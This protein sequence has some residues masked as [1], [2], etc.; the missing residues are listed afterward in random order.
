MERWDNTNGRLAPR[1]GI[2]QQDRSGNVGPAPSASDWRSALPCFGR[3]VGADPISFWAASQFKPRNGTLAASRGF[4]RR[5]T[6]A[7][8]SSRILELAG[9]GYRR[10]ADHSS[11]SSGARG[12]AVRQ[13]IP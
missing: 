9:N 8:A 13:S 3:W 6:I 5:S 2:G 10:V 1:V 11:T 12:T 7:L 4:D